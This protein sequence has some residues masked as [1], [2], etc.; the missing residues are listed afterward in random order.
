METNQIINIDEYIISDGYYN[1][2]KLTNDYNLEYKKERRVREFLDNKGTLNLCFLLSEKLKGIKIFYIKMGRHGGTYFHESLMQTYINWLYI[3]PN[4][5]FTRNE[6]KFCEAIIEAF[7]GILTFEMQKHIKGYMIDLY[8]NEL[9]L[10]IEYDE[11]YHEKRLNEDTLRQNAVQIKCK[12]QF[13][14]HKENDSIF[15]TISKINKFIKTGCGIPFDPPD[16]F[17]K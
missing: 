7:K 5:T 13:I 14:R 4:H 11:K 6:L 10:C 17:Y 15:N 12:C 2:T 1:V 9:N 8:C 16:D 3:L